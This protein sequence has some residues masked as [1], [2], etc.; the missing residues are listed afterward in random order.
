MIVVHVRAVD[1]RSIF[2]PNTAVGMFTLGEIVNGTHEWATF[3]CQVRSSACKDPVNLGKV[4]YFITLNT[5]AISVLINIYQC[6]L[7]FLN[8]IISTFACESIKLPRFDSLK[9]HCRRKQLQGA[10]SAVKSFP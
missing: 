7:V 2:G 8:C 3:S 4:M 9:C 10:V 1:Y 6:R 5:Y